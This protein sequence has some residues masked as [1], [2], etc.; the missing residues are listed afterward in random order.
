M[1]DAPIV[2]RGAG[3]AIRL[4]A[5]WGFIAR[6]LEA[7]RTFLKFA[8]VGAL[9]YVIYAGVLLLA[10]D[11]S[12][13]PFMPAKDTS[14]DLLLFTHEDSLLLTTTLIATQASIFG[15][16]IG[17][18]HW[19]FADREVVRKPLWI[20]LLQFEARALASTLG[21]LTVVVNGLA[22]GLGVHPIV[23]L[24][25]GL[26]AAFTWNWTWDSRYIWRRISAPK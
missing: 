4:S 2:A 10:Y 16:F 23:A 21:I 12:V 20:R 7:R 3:Q 8:M 26:V 18:S 19:T 6:H 17:H 25:I 9:G 5:F 15:V 14:V 24:P 1:D 13:L 11:L 22:L